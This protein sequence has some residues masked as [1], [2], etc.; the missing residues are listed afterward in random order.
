MI[1]TAEN[2][3]GVSVLSVLRL[4][5]YFTGS[6][7]VQQTVK[8]NRQ[9]GPQVTL[10]TEDYSFRLLYDNGVI[11]LHTYYTGLNNY[12]VKDDFRGPWPEFI[13]SSTAEEVHKAVSGFLEITNVYTKEKARIIEQS[14][15]SKLQTFYPKEKWQSNIIR[16][17]YFSGWVP[18][19]WR[20]TLNTRWT[21]EMDPQTGNN[22]PF[23]ANVVFSSRNATL[24]TKTFSQ[25]SHSAVIAVQQVK[26][27]I[28]DTIDN[29][30]IIL[31]E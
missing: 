6:W 19:F 13:S 24:Y 9:R 2:Y 29:L 20:R 25:R 18:T 14:E 12:T 8:G 31:S 5:N 23:Y 10:D 3:D 17:D 15:L 30:Q 22:L 16:R 27:E 1:S 28:Q 21:I 7:K 11:I 26:K 4:S